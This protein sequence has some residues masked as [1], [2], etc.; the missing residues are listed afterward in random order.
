MNIDTLIF[1]LI[2]LLLG[3]FGLM[4]KS[5]VEENDKYTLTKVKV[6]LGTFSLL[7]CGVLLIILSLAR[8]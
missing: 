6:I 4:I 1:G 8:D 7:I 5:N 2:C 3:L